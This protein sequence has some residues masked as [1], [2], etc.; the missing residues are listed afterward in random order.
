MA[1]HAEAA[2]VAPPLRKGAGAAGARLCGC[3]LLA[4]PDAMSESS[5]AACRCRAPVLPYLYDGKRYGA[6]KSAEG[7][8][9]FDHSHTVIEVC[10]GQEDA[11]A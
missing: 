3:L 11:Q 8:S 4:S 10:M 5:T 1:L 9:R 6:F 2:G 7:A